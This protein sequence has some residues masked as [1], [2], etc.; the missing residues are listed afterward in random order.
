MRI[1]LVYPPVNRLC[2]M[3]SNFF[4]LGLGYLSAML[5]AGGHAVRIYN[6]ELETEPFA[7]PTNISR[8]ENHRLFVDALQDDDHRVWRE[9]RTVLNDRPPD[10]IGF[11]C[12][13]ASVMP[14]LKM[15]ALA[16]DTTDARIV[17]GGM[18]PTI[19]PESTARYPQVDY[20]VAGEAEHTLVMLA[21]ALEQK[22]DPFFIDGVGAVVD[23]Q[24]VFKRP[25]PVIRDLA[26]LPFPNREDLVAFEKH[27]PFLQAMV[28][29]RGCPYQCT[30][31]SGREI[32]DGITRYLPVEYVAGEMTHLHDRFGVRHFSFYDDTLLTHARRTRALCRAIA[33]LPFEVRWSGFTRVDLVNADILEQVKASGCYSLGIGVEHASDAILARIRK[34]YARKQ[35]VTGIEAIKAAGIQVSMNLMTGFPFETE[36]DMQCNIDLI[37]ELGIPANINTFT[38]YPQSP[39]Y[40]E[41]LREGWIDTPIDWGKHSQHSLYNNFT[42]RIAP[43]RY[44]ELLYAMAQTADDMVAT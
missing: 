29:S 27:A 17:F 24:V 25:R 37:R 31:C 13:S 18:H 21:D 19:L 10:M 20:I 4:P 39:I 22:Q 35:I 1:L 34:G 7:P 26:A 11:S 30:F 32:T 44:R 38:P 36:A 23:D 42:R 6:A 5:K 2:N 15:A 9:F 12:T 41:G 28:T 40:A 33:D 8:L 3:N 14:C 16:K 43:G